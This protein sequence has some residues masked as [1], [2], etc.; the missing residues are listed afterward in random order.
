[1]RKRKIGIIVIVLFLSVIGGFFFL[2]NRFEKKDILDELININEL[3]DEFMDTYYEN[4]AS[5][6]S[7]ENRE[8]ILIVVSKEKPNEIYGAKKVVEAPNSIY[9]LE[10]EDEVSAYK[11][12]QKFE[13]DKQIYSVQE[14]RKYT[15]S[16]DPVANN[17]GTYNSWGIEKAGLDHAIRY[18]NAN[19][20]E[21]VTAA[22]IDT[23]CDMD[24]FN[25]SYEGKIEEVYNLHETDIYGNDVMFDHYGHGTHIAGTIAEGTPD[26]VKVLPIKVSDSGGLDSLAILD[27]ITYITDNHKADVINMSFGS[28]VS[29]VTIDAEYVVIEAARRENIIS[30]AAAGNS[31][32]DMLEVPGAF[33]NTIS[34]SAVDSDLNRAEFSSYNDAVT[35]SAPGVNILSINGVKSGTSMATPHAV[36]SVAFLKSIEKNLSLEMVID[37]LKQNAIDLGESGRD[38]FFGY[39]FIDL[40]SF[41]LCDENVTGSCTSLDGSN[42]F[43]PTSIAVEN[44]VLTP[45][46]YGS[47]TNIMPTEIKVSGDDRFNI[48]TLDQLDDVTITGYDP[49]ANGEQ[50]VTVNYLNFETSFKVSNPNNYEM[51]WKYQF[52][53]DEMGNPTDNYI[54]FGYLD[55]GM[56]LKK[57]YFPSTID[58]HD[59]IGIYQMDQYGVFGNSQDAKYYGEIYL[60]SS[61]T[62]LGY[63]ALRNVSSLWK[64]KS[65][66]D[67]LLVLSSAFEDLKMLSVVDANILFG[68]WSTGQFRGDVSLRE[69]RI[70]SNTEMI[71]YGAFEGCRFLKNITLPEGITEIQGRAFYNTGLTNIELPN[72]LEKIGSVAFGE[73]SIEGVF[74]PASVNDI[75][76]GAFGGRRFKEVSVSEQNTVYDSR[77]NCNAVIESSTNTLVLGSNKTVIPNDVVAIG[78]GA[79][80][81]AYI[82]NVEFPEGLE[83]IADDAFSGCMYLDTVTIPR[84]VNNISS[85]SFKIYFSYIPYGAKFYVYSSSYAHNYAL[86]NN[87]PYVLLDEIPNPPKIA[88]VWYNGKIDYLPFETLDITSYSVKIYYEGI[89]DPEIVREFRNPRYENGRDSLRHGDWDAWLTFDTSS[90]YYNL[91]MDIPVEV[92]KLTPEYEIPTD[93]YANINSTLADVDLPDGFEWEDASILL[94]EVGDIVY[95]ARYIPEDNNN[96]EIVEDIAIPIHVINKT[97]IKPTITVADKTYDGTSD[98][99]LD[100]FTISDIDEDDYSLVSATLK[101]ANVGPTKALITLRLTDDKFQN[102]AFSNGMQEKV[103]KIDIN[104]LQAVLK[105]PTAVDKKYVYNDQYQTLEIN[106]Y[107]NK[108]M[109]ISGNKQ[110]DAGEYL[111]KITL[112]DYMNYRWEDPYGYQNLVYLDF[113]IEKASIDYSVYGNEYMYDGQ[114]HG[115]SVS[116]PYA[117]TIKYMDE[118]GNFTLDESPQYVDP[119]EYNVQFMIT[120]DGGNYKTTYGKTTLKIKSNGIVNNTKDMEIL[121]DAME[122]S[123]ELDLSVDTYSVRY[124]LNNVEYNKNTLPTFRDVGEYTIHYE[125]S[126][127]GYDTITGSNKVKIYGVKRFDSSFQLRDDN[128]LVVN[129]KSYNEVINKTTTYSTSSDFQHYNSSNQLTSS[130]KIKTGD[131]IKVKIN[132][133]KTYTYTIA[134]AGDVDGDGEIGIIDY[135]RIMKDIM[136]GPKLIGANFEAADM[137][138]NCSIDIVDYVR[139]MKIIMEDEE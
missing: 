12:K 2:R 103:F 49:Y 112:K 29:E 45:Y 125:V 60:P 136:D 126:S 77:D 68:L 95:D 56:A 48:V 75:G 137:N 58:N 113:V 41:V 109:T 85:T 1:M 88:Q 24:L 96:Y 16:E 92:G 51:G 15:F 21:S 138:N 4:M 43:I 116:T 98:L 101:D 122:H 33:D 108:L 34:I 50:T 26:N 79:F 135:I 7:S 67:E 132:N 117:A 18:I 63:G 124:F 20:G 64:V 72:K 86:N 97:L 82:R 123:F 25:A 70:S 47:L 32:S 69:I 133:E 36:C 111:V 84:S 5:L 119:G 61:I 134:L 120:I 131:V 44:V 57:L 118:Y 129:D 94:D 106:N 90:G 89:D 23:G 80:K 19:G 74:I 46:N 38:R 107:N 65:D 6:L 11:A 115:V 53:R 100:S 27:A 76:G 10:Y 87:Y 40:S 31:N 62:T 93:I 17:S 52:E 139:V 73:T 91:E 99:P 130:D 13:E 121:Y 54:I 59:V 35:F 104:I 8:N 127:D 37:A 9:Y 22:I 39:G 83:T 30:V 66:A 42:D 55:N 78:A 128:I 105:V 3:D 110:K 14:N 81:D 114:S 28:M 71:P 102:Y